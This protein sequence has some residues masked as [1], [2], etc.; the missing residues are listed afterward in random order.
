[1]SVDDLLEK[2]LFYEEI[3]VPAHHFAADLERISKVFLQDA[4]VA[5]DLLGHLE[6]AAAKQDGTHLPFF[7]R[8]SCGEETDLLVAQHG[9]DRVGALEDHQMVGRRLPVRIKLLPEGG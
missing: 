1:M 3:D 4:W 5:C 7:E 8:E 2:S 6:H 9:I